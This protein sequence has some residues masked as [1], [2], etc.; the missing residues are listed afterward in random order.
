M[1]IRDRGRGSGEQTR[2]PQAQAVQHESGGEARV[3]GDGHP[4]VSTIEIPDSPL[5]EPDLA[6]QP[7]PIGVDAS[8]DER[9]G[10]GGAEIENQVATLVEQQE[11][12]ERETRKK[13]LRV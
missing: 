9:M 10:M 3:D 7:F 11:Q 6:T 2:D 5:R 1:C 12:E 4:P 13:M 8:L